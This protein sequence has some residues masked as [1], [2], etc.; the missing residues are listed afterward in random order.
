MAH[1]TFERVASANPIVHLFIELDDGTPADDGD[2]AFDTASLNIAYKRELASSWSAF[3]GGNIEDITTIGAYAAPTSGKVRFKYSGR[4]GHFDLMLPQAAT[5]T[6]D[7]SRTLLVDVQAPGCKPCAATIDLAVE[8]TVSSGKIAAALD[9]TELDN[10][11]ARVDAA[12]V[13]ADLEQNG[14]AAAAIGTYSNG[15]GRLLAVVN[16]V[17]VYGKNVAVT[18]FAFY[19]ELTDGSPGTGLT[20][21]AT[22]SKDGGAFAGLAGSVTEISAGWYKVDIAQAEMN[23]DEVALKFTAPG[24]K[25][26]N[27]K[28]RTQA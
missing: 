11:E 1:Q 5:G 10:V 15:A 13:A 16:N 8:V 22:V 2:L 6:G 4:A 14:A 20:V 25:Q 9:S 18:A 26:R 3:S 19:M 28:I 21:T 17:D 27:I 7:A 12:I 23:A 24:A